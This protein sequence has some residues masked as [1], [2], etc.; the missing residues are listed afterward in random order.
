MD[1]WLEEF[2]RDV[3]A[4]LLVYACDQLNR[5]L[6]DDLSA[7]IEERLKIDVGEEMPRTYV[8]DVA[9]SEPWDT[10]G[11]RGGGTAIA[12]ET[13]QPVIVDFAELKARYLE[14][15][16]SAG[17]VVTVLEVLSPSNKSD[18][19]AR[20]DWE[21][22][23]RENLAAGINFV[24]LDLVRTGGWGLPPHG[25]FLH[26]PLGQVSHAAS[27]LRAADPRRCEFYL[28][29]LRKPLP[30]IRIPLRLGEPDVPLVLQ[31]LI[32]RSYEGGRYGRKINYSRDP[33]PPLPPDELAWAREIVAARAA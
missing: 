6:P 17:H 30:A 16:D 23:R 12:V 9:I 15:S 7:S 27:V 31:E 25:D 29:P 1:P 10:A 2:W 8:P 20:E 22:K 28:F 11:T 5:R 13:A 18:S 26:I 24:E 33:Q 4:H 14:L 19:R 32:D 3:H 21:R